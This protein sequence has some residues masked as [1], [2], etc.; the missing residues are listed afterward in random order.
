MRRITTHTSLPRRVALAALLAALGACARGG[1]GAATPADTLAAAPTPRASG[2]RAAPGAAMGAAGD[3]LDDNQMLSVLEA[4][5]QSEILPSQVAQQNARNAELREYARRMI[6]EH[7][8][9]G[10]SMNA[11]VAAMGLAPA[12]HPLAEGMS[13]I[14]AT[15]QRLRGL[16][17]MDFDTAYA[18]LMAQSHRTA[19]ST[20]QERMIPR[21]QNAQ[22]RAALEQKVRPAV[23]MHLRDI[24][25]IR[26]TLGAQ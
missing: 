10:D 7:T 9:L 21:A 11:Q 20:V 1:D 8:A 13:A 17:G 26:G 23:E 22:L 24:E 3:S 12:G 6:A 4:M 5:N 18:A 14:N 15:T 2:E 25:R 19:L 16:Q